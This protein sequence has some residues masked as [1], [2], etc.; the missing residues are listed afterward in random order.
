MTEFILK[1]FSKK[2]ED[3]SEGRLRELQGSFA[4]LVGIIVN[5]LISVTK[6]VFGLASASVALIADALNNLSDAGSSVVTLV[7]FKL[8]GKPADKDH[9]FGHARI[10]YIASMIVS[11]FI[12]IVG[13]E[14][15]SDSLKALFNKDSG[16]AVNFST[17]SL[18]VIAITVLFKLWLAIFY[19]KI[20]KKINST[21]IVASSTDCFLDCFSTVAVLIS[22]IV[23]K[24]TDFVIIDA[25]VG[26]CVSSLIFAAGIKILNE[27]KNS[28]LGEAPTE[29]VLSQI[30]EIIEKYPD[31]VGTHDIMLHNYGP[32]HYILSFHAEV[33]GEKD[34]FLLHDM[35][36]NLEKEIN[37]R[38][39][40]LCTIHMDPISTNDEIVMSY[41]D[42]MSEIVERV[43]GRASSIHDFRVVVGETHTNLIFDVVL[44]F[45]SKYTPKEA[46]S[47]IQSAVSSENANLYCVIT[48]DR[49]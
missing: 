29:D 17:V 1:L 46:I 23:V 11:F 45:D 3:I 37:T 18:I 19:R 5:L 34:I 40:M 16:G 20:G 30:F 35:I 41:K 12:L 26:I 48:V 13:F 28:I 15:L 47:E 4:S 43:L 14:M 7:S 31:V 49:G 39:N 44:P 22:A 25:I 24:F 21:T 6:L 10:E 27:T 9:P 42:F 33:D 8:S 32:E 36:D 38:L 2:S